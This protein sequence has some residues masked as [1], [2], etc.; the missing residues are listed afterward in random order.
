MRYF[1]KWGIKIE[2][3]IDSYIKIEKKKCKC[4]T[5][6]WNQVYSVYASLF[7]LLSS[8]MWWVTGNACRQ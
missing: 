5:L 3:K 6:F 7:Y 4:S 8:K 1:E 2:K